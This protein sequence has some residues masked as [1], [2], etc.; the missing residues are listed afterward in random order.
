MPAGGRPAANRATRKGLQACLATGD[1]AGGI[2]L[3]SYGLLWLHLAMRRVGVAELKNNLSRQLRA[4]EAGEQIEVT[5]HD[6]PIARLVPA[7]PKRNLV[8]QRASRPFSEVANVRYAPLD[9]P[10]NSTQ[11]LREDRDRR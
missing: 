10:I 1:L 2:T 3:D 4:V 6:R 11:L 8:I 5:D 9:L 7:G